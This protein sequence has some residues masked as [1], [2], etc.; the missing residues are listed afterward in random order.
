MS[1]EQ[2]ANVKSILNECL[3]LPPD[4]RQ[5]HLD[6][7]CEGNSEIRCEVESLLESHSA[8]GEKFLETSVLDQPVETL[9]G[10]QIGLYQVVERIG[11]GGMGSVYRAVRESDF[12]IAGPHA[13]GD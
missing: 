12:H 5:A 10:R 9:I 4:R 13:G 8:A 6:T 2:W 3:D 7:A 11:E 1:P